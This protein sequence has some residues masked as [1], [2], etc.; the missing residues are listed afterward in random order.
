M[1][2]QVTGRVAPAQTPML[3][4][5][6]EV[7]FSLLRK[8]KPF[9]PKRS[10]PNMRVTPVTGNSVSQTLIVTVPFLKLKV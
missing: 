10:L 3:D 4:Y 7:T 9:F 2:K 8:G 1:H 6:R 5:L